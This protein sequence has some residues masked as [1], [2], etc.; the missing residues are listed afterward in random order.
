MYSRFQRWRK[1]GVGKKVLAEPQT[2][3]D[4]QGE[5]SWQI[6]LEQGAVFPR[7]TGRKPLYPKRLISDKG[8]TSRKF[9]SSFGKTPYC[10]DH[11]AQGKRAP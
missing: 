2:L 8:Y 11:P 10:S 1:K 4:Q 6:H 9:R 3:A 7:T 5:L